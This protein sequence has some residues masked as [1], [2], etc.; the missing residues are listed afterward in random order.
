MP[1]KECGRVGYTDKDG[2]TVGRNVG[3]PNCGGRNDMSGV[4]RDSK[5]LLDRSDK[6]I[7][8]SKALR[9]K[10]KKALSKDIRKNGM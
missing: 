2:N 10:S 9:K 6:N 4:K 7:A 1:N 3:G 5:A 8:A